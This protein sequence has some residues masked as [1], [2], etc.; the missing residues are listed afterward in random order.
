VS[1]P[2]TFLLS[3][4]NDPIV[5]EPGGLQRLYCPPT[6]FSTQTRMKSARS[7]TSMNWNGSAGFPGASISPPF[8]TR[9]GQYVKRSVTS[10]G[11]AM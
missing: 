6:R 2:V 10:P 11:P 1:A 3:S 9:N 4:S 5:T 8:E 7:R